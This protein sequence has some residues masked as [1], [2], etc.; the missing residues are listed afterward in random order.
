MGLMKEMKI[1]GSV[2]FDDAEINEITPDTGEDLTINLLDNAGVRKVIV[3]DSDD[4]TVFTIDSNG[5]VTGLQAV[6]NTLNAA[7]STHLA[8]NGVTGKDV[9]VKLTDASGSRKLIILDSSDAE[10]ATIDSNGDIVATSITASV[11]G[12]V[13]GNLT[14][15]VTAIN[16]VSHDYSAGHADWTLSAAEK[17]ADILICTNADAGANIIGPAE[18][19][20]YIVRNASGQA[21]T[22]KKSAGTGIA[23]ANGKT[24][25]VK[26]SSS[27]ADYIRVTA[28]ATH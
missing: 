7:A 25:V 18:N 10:V 27:V 14:G 24:A 6:V 16:D 28:D 11:V 3:K 19:R 9:K 20:Q 13:T 1:V 26:Y 22:I 5:V 23:I 4:V 15:S 2:V 8:I 17:K 21:I 12:D